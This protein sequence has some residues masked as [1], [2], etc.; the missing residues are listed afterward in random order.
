MQSRT[1]VLSTPEPAMAEVQLNR[2]LL[3][4]P[5]IGGGRSS[6]TTA[7]GLSRL[8]AMRSWN[9]RSTR[10]LSLRNSICFTPNLKA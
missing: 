6:W 10:G 8:Q 4:R 3:A 1:G 2:S 5:V 9:S 7:A